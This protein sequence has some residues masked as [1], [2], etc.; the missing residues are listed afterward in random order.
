MLLLCTKPNF[1]SVLVC[2]NKKK[3]DFEVVILQPLQCR[4]YMLIKTSHLSHRTMKQKHKEQNMQ[5]NYEKQNIK[6]QQENDPEC[7]LR[8]WNSYRKQNSTS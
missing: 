5:T 8:E 3:E 4:I 1:S 7:C 2:V 6:G